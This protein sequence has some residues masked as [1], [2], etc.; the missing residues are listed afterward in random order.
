[1][2]INDTARLR[3]ELLKHAG[4]AKTLPMLNSMMNEVFRIMADPES[5]FAQL[6]EVVKY[7]QAISSKIISI[8]NSTYYNRGT[9]VTNLERAMVM[10]GFKE[11]ERAIMCL[12]FMKQI[13]APWRL[14]EDDV[15]AV[16]E[17]SLTVA[18]AARTLCTKTAI[19]D[20][21]KAFAISILHDIGKIIFYA[22][23]DDYVNVAN[24]A[25]LGAQDICDLERAK[26]GVDH[27]ELGYHMSVK[28]GFPEEF[29]EVILNHHGPHD[30]KVPII[31]IVR[32]ADA[33]ACRRE[34]TLPEEERTILGHEK[35]LIN[36]ET[37]R[38]KLLMVA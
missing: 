34:Y 2:I 12:V 30:G 33:F 28:W 29:S 31:D 17:H 18:H 7:D 23:G 1:V 10:V 11:V 27:Q 38:I 13:M 4:T 16:W 35:E 32:D 25:R 15:A 24:D 20:P 36:A 21:E 37:T 14:G 5:S 9:P 22:Y 19:E 8:A 3:E 6:Y 26:Y